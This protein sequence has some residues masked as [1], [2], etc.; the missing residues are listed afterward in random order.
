MPINVNQLEIPKASAHALK[1]L[2][3][4]TSPEPDMDELQ[5]AIMQD[6]VLASTLIRYANSPLYRRSQEITNVPI[7]LRLLGLK[8]V[9]SAIVMATIRSALPAESD[10]DRRILDHLQEIA[11]FCK[12]IAKQCC[13]AAADDLEFLGLFH[14]VGM[15]ILA[16]NTEQEYEQMLA[17]AIEQRREVDIC[18]KERFGISHDVVTGRAAHEFRLPESH[19]NLLKCFHSREAINKAETEQEID[20][21]VVALAHQLSGAIRNHEV[22][23]KET[24]CETLPQLQ[25]ALGLSDEQIESLCEEGKA[26]LHPN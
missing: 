18:E 17:A 8:S 14:D 5:R 12:L 10:L 6:P 3:I 2:Q 15:L 24:I 9:R 22:P 26:L 16:A 11:M 13:P 21:C 23:F 1:A 19:Q 4:I 7:A 20:T 25:A